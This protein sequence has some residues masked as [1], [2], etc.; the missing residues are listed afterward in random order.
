MILIFLAALSSVGVSVLLKRYAPIHILPV[1]VWNYLVAT[2]LCFLWFKPQFSQSVVWWLI[3][4]CAVLLPSI[5]YL[6]AQSLKHAGLVKTE[7][8][9]RL[10]VVVS[11][12]AAYFIFNDHFSDTKLLGIGLGVLS[13]I[14]LV[15]KKEKQTL[16]QKGILALICVWLGYALVDVLLKYNSS[17]GQNFSASLNL[18]FLGAFILTLLST[19]VKRQSLFN[20]HTFSLGISVGVLNFLNIALYVMAHRVNAP[21]TVF[22]TMNLSVV[23]IGTLL[24]VVYFKEKLTPIMGV[25]L[26]FACSAIACLVF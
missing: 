26:I 11:L 20:K 25:S 6:L 5:F 12:S 17:L 10:S 8:A 7:I 18:I 23:L 19:F 13:I 9:Q 15:S 4:A 2:L 22:L 14:G 16:T 21:S 24:G 1:L 3:I